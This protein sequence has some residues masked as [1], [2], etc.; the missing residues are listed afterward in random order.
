MTKLLS[1]NDVMKILNIKDTI[2]ILEKAFADLAGGRAVMPPRAYI[3]V[4]EHNGLVLYMPAYLKGL[5]A[6]G[7]KVVTVYK[8]NVSK[9][10]LPT[11]CGTIILLDEKSG[12]PIAIMEGS[13]LTAM[14]TGAV[15][16][17]AT[18]LL[19]R[20][21]A[22][23]HALFGTGGMAKAH[24]L[25][26][27][28]IRNIDKLIIVSVDSDEKKNSFAKSI[29]K[30][31]KS[32]III[33]KSAEEAVQQADIVTLITTARKPVIDGGWIRPGTHING[34]GS[35]EPSTREIDTST[36]IR[37]KVV[38]DLLEACKPEAGDFLIPI[39]E[40]KWSWDKVH[41][42]LGEIVTGKK[43]GRESD[44][45]ITLFKSV[46]LAIQDVSVALHVY[47]KS[48]ETG[49]GQDFSF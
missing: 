2:E 16:G 41:A 26:V 30:I 23:I 28:S 32:E 36:V 20:K 42:S 37:S 10:N 49:L 43:S 7:T 9:Y 15:S 8:D 47:N 48:I 13:F 44:D 5:G 29:E 18:K 45:E 31:L 4:P 1:G 34:A 3:A 6:L 39:E 14:R 46:G 21:D 24:A 12:A 22:K 19:S 38:C 27:D 40:N 25:A 17:L 33:A 11:I 35:H